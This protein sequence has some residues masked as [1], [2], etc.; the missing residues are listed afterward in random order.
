MSTQ[1][2]PTPITAPKV[3]PKLLAAIKA[4]VQAGIKFTAAR[5]NTNKVAKSETV[6]NS[7]DQKT[8]QALLLA[9]GI[10]ARG[11]SEICKFVFP[12]NAE[13]REAL[14]EI[15][16][17]NGKQ[18][19]H[20]KRISKPVLL[21]IARAK[22]PLSIDEAKKLVAADKQ[23]TAGGK[24]NQAAAAIRDAASKTLTGKKLEEAV[25]NEI[26][27]ALAKLKKD[28]YSK[29]DAETILSECVETSFPEDDDASED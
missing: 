16:E 13:N 9:N 15:I 3:S 11:A 19:D 12:A 6:H 7:W 22:E 4:D 10:D 20:K 21:A 26:C 28:E 23:R 25:K 2:N 17:F 1:A 24:T 5:D 8:L 18:T 27:A 29:E 14:D